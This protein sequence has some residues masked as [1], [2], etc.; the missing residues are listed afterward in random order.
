MEDNEEVTEVVLG[1]KKETPVSESHDDFK[2]GYEEVKKYMGLSNNLKRR[3]DRRI[4]KKAGTQQIE[5]DMVDGYTYLDCVMPPENIDNLAKLYDISPAHHAAV[6]AKVASIFGLGWQLVES[7]RYKRLK[8]GARTQ[9][10]HSRAE[11]FLKKAIDEVEEFLDNCNEQDSFEE[12]LRKIGI[13]YESTGNAYLEI[14][15]DV[16]GK[17]RYIG[18]IPAQHMRVRRERDGFVQIY[19]NHVAY[20]RNFGEKN[21]NP[22]TTE[23]NPN[24][25]IHFKKYTPTNTYYG[26][27]D[28]FSAKNSLAGNEFASRYNLDFFENQAIPRYAIV[29]RQS[30]LSAQSINKL[31]E[32]FESGV[33]GQPHRTIFI[34]LAKDVADAEIKFEQIDTGDKDGAFASFRSDNNEDIFM[35]HR[36]PLTRAGVYAKGMTLAAAKDADKVFKESVSSPE[37][38]IFEKKFAKVIREKSDAVIFKLNELSLTDEDTQSKIDEREAR[39]GITVPDEIRARKGEGPRPDGKGN[40]PWQANSQQRAEQKAQATRNRTRDSDRSAGAT[41]SAG[42]GRNAKGDGRSTS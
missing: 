8:E 24:E 32:F 22:V 35:A 29:A 5:P 40:E 4:N 1:R 10:G 9:G 17:I 21:P 20:F 31:V 26:L 12:I 41:D 15:R 7:K 2:T 6:D 18:Q 25:V 42:E 16:T 11:I 13:D 39:M 30:S 38:Q 19:S 28:I 3:S 23:P 14:G 33:R 27:P 34:P 36:T 37:Q